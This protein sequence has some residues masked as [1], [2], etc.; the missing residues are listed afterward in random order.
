MKR[1]V[2]RCPA[3]WSRAG[4]RRLFVVDIENVVGGLCSSQEMATWARL[5]LEAV[6]PPSVGDHVVVGTCHLGLLPAGCGWQGPRY[7]V[8]SGR[9][10]A[11]LALLEVLAEGVDRRFDELVIVSGDGIFAD[12]AA[13]LG[14]AGLAVTVVAHQDG[15]SRRLRM[16]ATKVVLFDSSYAAAAALESKDVA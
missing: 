8:G 15:L 7:V 11:D 13:R 2:Q 1:T 3:W 12:A 9:D 16:A 6:L 5:A 14:G 4:R 10:G